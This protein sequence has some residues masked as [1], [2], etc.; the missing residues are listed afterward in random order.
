M[1]AQRHA[2]ALLVVAATA[3]AAC[4]STPRHGTAA[5]STT[6]NQLHAVVGVHPAGPDDGARMLDVFL[7]ASYGTPDHDAAPIR[8]AIWPSLV[9][10]RGTTIAYEVYAPSR[11]DLVRAC[12]VFGT[13]AGYFVGGT[14]YQLR[15]EGWVAEPGGGFAGAPF[16]P[17][18]CARAP[19]NDIDPV[20]ATR[21]PTSIDRAR[22]VAAFLAV[23][24]K[25]RSWYAGDGSGDAGDGSPVAVVVDV[26]APDPLS[27]CGRLRSITD[28]FLG[29]DAYQLRVVP[30]TAGRTHPSQ[31]CPN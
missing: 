31:G 9:P 1:R 15:L 30:T 12:Q 3:V 17:V 7:L 4:S 6:Q 26:S 8:G 22:R 10:P 28:W 27:F 16:P 14:P 21:P 23:Y 2:A 24:L 20:A 18:T 5:S 19:G 29:G 13:A 25:G 11:D